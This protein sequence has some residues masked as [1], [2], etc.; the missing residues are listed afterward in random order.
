MAETECVGNRGLA[1]CARVWAMQGRAIV[2][3][4]IGQV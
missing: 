3:P 1:V 2:R 4:Y